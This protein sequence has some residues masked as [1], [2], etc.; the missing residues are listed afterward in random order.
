MPFKT[1]TAVKIILQNSLSADFMLKLTDS[2]SEHLNFLRKTVNFS[3]I[4]TMM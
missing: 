1:I 2:V 4:Y 3:L